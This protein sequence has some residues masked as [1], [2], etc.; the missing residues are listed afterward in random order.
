MEDRERPR[1]GVGAAAAPTPANADAPILQRRC[2]L[3]CLA[4][5]NLLPSVLGMLRASWTGLP[6]VVSDGKIGRHALL[7]AGHVSRPADV[8]LFARPFAAGAKSPCWQSGPHQ[9]AA[10]NTHKPRRRTALRAAGIIVRDDV[11]ERGTSRTCPICRQAR[12]ANR[13]HRG[14]YRCQCGWRAHAD[15]NGALNLYE[16]AFQVSPLKGS[17]GRVARPVVV[18]FQSGWHTV[19]EP[20]RKNLRASA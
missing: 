19:H 10:A 15:V 6:C 13:I 5:S 18:S 16:R 9:Q 20:K 7:A 12:E 8:R 17:S 3:A 11:D 4:K 14:W 1:G 2:P